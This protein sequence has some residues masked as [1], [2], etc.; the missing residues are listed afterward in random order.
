MKA[1]PRPLAPAPTQRLRLK[2]GRMDTN[3]SAFQYNPKP[4]PKLG[5]VGLGAGPI[6][7]WRSLLYAWLS[8]NGKPTAICSR[9][10]TPAE[11]N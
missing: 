4:N 11:R 2:R 8:Q 3:S 5:L 1:C 7:P 10:L 6:G 9:A